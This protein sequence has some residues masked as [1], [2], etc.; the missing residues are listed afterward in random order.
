VFDDVI[1]EALEGVA[2]ITLNRPEKLN[3]LRFTTYEE[4]NAALLMAGEDPTVGVV[5]IAGA[6]RAFCAGGDLD[7]AN[8]S[9]TTEHAG[10][11]HYIHRMVQVSQTMQQLSVPVICQ[12]QG[13]CVGGGAEMAVFADFIYAAE[14][15]FFLFN[16]TSI[17]GCSWWGAPQ[18]LPLQVGLRQA[19]RILLLSERVRGAEA[20]EI[21]LVNKCVPDHLL[22]L[23]VDA[24]CQRILDLSEDG[25]RLTKSS[26]RSVKASLLATMVSDAEANVAVLGNDDLHAAFDAVKDGQPFSWRGLRQKSDRRAR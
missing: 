3:A 23:E 22:G 24:L 18:L 2:R 8:E 4:L 13:P 17:G 21:G 16:G 19:E 15:S 12:V 11:F 10:R 7:M 20:Q 9:L 6:G 5:V 26:L 14:S 1:Y 25:L